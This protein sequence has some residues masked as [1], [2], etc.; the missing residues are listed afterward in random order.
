MTLPDYLRVLRDRWLIILTVVMIGGLAAGGSWFLRPQEYTASL[1]MY[2]SAQTADTT[3]SAYQ[4]AQLSEQRITSYIEVINSDL[5]REDVAGYLDTD[6]LG[7]IVASSN[8]NSVLIRVAVTHV[9]PQHAADVA[10]AVGSV[11]PRLVDQLERP[12]SPAAIAPVSVRV[13]KQA[14]VPVRASSV[15]LPVTLA[16]GLLGGLALGIGAALARNALDRSVTSTEHLRQATDA[17]SLGTVAYDGDVP[18]RPLTVHED[19]QS[20]RSEAFR[21]LRT[22]LRFVDVDNPRS[23]IVVTSSVAGEGKTNTLANLG[24]ALASAGHKVVVVE[25]DLRRPKLSETLGLD[26]AVGVTSVLSGQLQIEQV[27]QRGPGGVDLLSSGPLPPNPSEI[28]ASRQMQT[29]IGKLR[30]LYDTVL[31]DTPPV[32]PVTDAAAVAPATDGVILV[33][34]YRSTTRDQVSAARGAL[35]SVSASL[36]GTVLTMTPSSGPQAYQ[37]YRSYERD[38]RAVVRVSPGGAKLPVTPLRPTVID[39]EDAEP[40]NGASRPRPSPTPRPR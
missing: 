6:D 7:E 15:S 40:R 17:P 3:S 5:L 27:I 13:M 21:A 29:L 26:N 32:L 4:G 19:P 8:P 38:E 2:V 23:V 24:I 35:K 10:N 33:C 34:R 1:T 12:A 16:I 18:K 31:I 25:A 11:F 14:S 30:A 37:Q 9:S 36:L 20:P 39:G 28:L 22:N